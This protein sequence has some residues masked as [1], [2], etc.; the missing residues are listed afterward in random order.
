[1]HAAIFAPLT[2]LMFRRS[3]APYFEAGRAAST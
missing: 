2:Y 1:M 3:A